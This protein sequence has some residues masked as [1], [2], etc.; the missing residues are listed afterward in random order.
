MPLDARLATRK[1]P[2]RLVSTTAPNSS[3]LIRM[4]SWSRVMPALDT[5]TSTGPSS[6]STAAKAAST[7][8]GSVTSIRTPSRP[9]GGRPVRWVTATRSPC[10][11]KAR[12]MA[13]PIPRLP[14]VTSTTRPAGGFGCLLGH[15]LCPF[16]ERHGHAGDRG[17]LRE[18]RTHNRPLGDKAGPG[19]LGGS[20]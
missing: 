17:A 16:V 5:T 10:A 2:P 4:I 6:A 13:S 12:A 20:A 1:A 9:S 19:K 18:D 3:S 7:D 8:A 11:A 14:P 15:G